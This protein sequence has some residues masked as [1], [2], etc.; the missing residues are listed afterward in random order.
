MCLWHCWKVSADRGHRRVRSRSCSTVFELNRSPGIRW[1]AGNISTWPGFTAKYWDWSEYKTAGTWLQ[2]QN[3]NKRAIV[4][5]SNGGSAATW[6]ATDGFAIDLLVALDPTVWLANYALESNVK[7]AVCFHDTFILNP[8]GHARC[9]KGI[10]LAVNHGL[11]S[12]IRENME[13]Q[14]SDTGHNRYKRL[15]R[16]RRR[17]SENH[18]LRVQRYQAFVMIQA[19]LKVGINEHRQIL[20][21]PFF[22]KKTEIPSV[23]I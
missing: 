10:S 8:V 13:R 9:T 21:R 23:Y 22:L 12:L 20:N 7:S 2:S 3:Q 14:K 17:R 5:Y 4:G 1:M 16:R 15:A 19:R 6:V 18:E 11:I